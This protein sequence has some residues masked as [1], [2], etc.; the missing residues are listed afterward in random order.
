MGL[1]NSMALKIAGIS[2]STEDPGG[3]A[4]MRNGGGGIVNVIFLYQ[5]GLFF[6]RI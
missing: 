2:K 4:V 3:G 5:V 6:W 1:A